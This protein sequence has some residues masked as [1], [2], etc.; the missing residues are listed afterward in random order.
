[1]I[2]LIDYSNEFNN[3][4]RTSKHVFAFKVLQLERKNC[5]EKKGV[6][7]FLEGVDMHYSCSLQSVPDCL[8]RKYFSLAFRD[9][10]IFGW[11]SFFFD[12]DG[13]FVNLLLSYFRVVMLLWYPEAIKAKPKSCIYRSYWNTFSR[14]LNKLG[15]LFRF[16]NME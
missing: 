11:L 14:V 4:R 9:W 16:S 5:N 12:F 8:M 6:S 10:T 3:R 15:R 7:L 1:M 13:E 2:I